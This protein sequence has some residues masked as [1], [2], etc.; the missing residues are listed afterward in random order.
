MVEKLIQLIGCVPPWIPVLDENE[1][2]KCPLF[3]ALEDKEK[4]KIL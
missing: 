1:D 3:Y 2:K 4:V